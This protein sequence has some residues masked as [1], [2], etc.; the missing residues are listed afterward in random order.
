MKGT[1]WA[2]SWWL[3]VVAALGGCDGVEPDCVYERGG[4][5]IAHGY[6][7]FNWE[8]HQDLDV[9]AVALC[10]GIEGGLT[11]SNEVRL[12][13]LKWISGPLRLRASPFLDK[14]ANVTIS[15]PSLQTVG[16]ALHIHRFEPGQ[17]RP[18][19]DL[20]A[21]ERVEGDLI[22]DDV[23][24]ERLTLPIRSIGGNL[25]IINQSKLVELD[26]PLLES[27]G[28]DLDAGG[29]LNC[30]EASQQSAGNPA[31]ARILVPSLKTVGGAVK[32]TRTPA[33]SALD[34]PALTEARR[35]EILGA[36][37]LASIFAP[38][39][40]AAESVELRDNPR[41]LAL[42]LP[43][44]AALTGSPVYN[45]GTS[46]V[47]GRQ[48]LAMSGNLALSHLALPLLVRI[49]GKLDLTG[50]PELFHLGLE[51][52]IA[53]EGALI[54][55]NGLRQ[56]VMPALA[57]ATGA[58]EVRDEPDLERLEI[59]ALRHAGIIALARLPALELAPLPALESLG[60]LTIEALDGL[61]RLT[62][63]SAAT[64]GALNLI[65]NASLR[66]LDLPPQAEMSGVLLEDNPALEAFALPDLRVLSGLSI[67][68]QPALTLLD[69]PL[70][71]EVSF[72]ALE[73]N[74]ALIEVSLPS[75]Q[76][77]GTLI[78]LDHERLEALRAP[79][80]QGL[81]VRL[82]VSRNAALHTLALSGLT[83]AGIVEIT[84]NASLPDCE[85]EVI[86]L[87][88]D[89]SAESVTIADNLGDGL[90]GCQ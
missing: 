63:P 35:L 38:H 84:A 89:R 75:L 2:L 46:A 73:D 83:Q 58:L 85:A 30:P 28:G 21:L 11:I 15:L 24:F 60:T 42:D 3:L 47:I 77:G 71:E 6:T 12:G 43:A 14:P 20:S 34:L 59:P 41:L 13:R 51:R 29:C 18:G 74:D 10:E 70:L 87:Q 22:L 54:E 19:L 9:A 8:I 88:L 52:L 68:G 7:G 61:E 25:R 4:D 36:S 90:D 72:I 26:L 62:V 16:G 76:R 49:D 1:R 40:A 33:L 78:A 32:I 66:A 67:H 27:I 79:L 31:L 45:P 53:I 86:R 5:R 55:R 81:S 57:E 69:L 23:P 37:A 48:G 82:H 64:L 39:L 80:L 44:L 50:N 65:G 17:G 56:I